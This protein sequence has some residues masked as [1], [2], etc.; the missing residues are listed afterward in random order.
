MHY[1]GESIAV[2]VSVSWTLAAL[3]SE[4]ATKRMGVLN[5]NV[6][7]MLLSMLFISLLLLCFTGSPLP[8]Y[9]T[10]RAWLWLGLSGLVGYTFGDICL[11]RSY[12]IIGSRFGQL[13]MTLAPIAASIAGWAILG[14]SMSLKSIVAMLIVI[15]GIAMSVLTRKGG[16]EHHHRKHLSFKMPLSGVLYGIGAGVGQGVGLVLSG[17]G[18]EYY[19]LN[20]P[21]GA[22][23][24]RWLMPFSSTF[25]RAVFGGTSFILLMGL[26]HKFG[27]LGRSV[28]D[29]KAMGATLG[30]TMTGPFI[31][32]SMSLM[33]LRYTS[34]GIAQTLMSLTPVFILL[35]S[36][37]LFKQKITKLEVVGTIISV[38][39]ASLFF[40]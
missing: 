27:S 6:V 28:R 39:G 19:S 36:Y 2:A 22:D 38:L 32:V 5:L 15:G 9:T 1:I 18:M 8:S 23:A 29:V 14:Q 24:V 37:F 40:L 17:K 13:F 3:F 12:L 26:R 11:F 31:G 30:A 25:M 16:D 20:I 7:R 34:A 35:P 4:A 33:A 21:E 10:P